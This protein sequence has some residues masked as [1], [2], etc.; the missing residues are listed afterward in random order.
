[1]IISFLLYY[2]L[3]IQ[4]LIS[5]CQSVSVAESS[6]KSVSSHSLDFSIENCANKRLPTNSTNQSDI[7]QASNHSFESSNQVD[8]SEL[9][10]QVI[11]QWIEHLE[12]FSGRSLKSFLFIVFNLSF[13]Y[14][15]PNAIWYISLNYSSSS[16]VTLLFN[17]NLLFAF[18]FSSIFLRRQFK[19]N[20]LHLVSLFL[21]LTSLVLIFVLDKHSTSSTTFGDLL[22]LSSAALYGLYQVI[23]KKLL[24]KKDIIL[25]TKE[26]L[27]FTNYVTFLI[28]IF[29]LLFQW[30]IVLFSHY[31][32]NI[33]L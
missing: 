3:T 11:L 32:S 17:T 16:K 25:S 10:P 21:A 22:A 14:S 8:Q 7:E 6:L 33:S 18:L 5:K 15:L 30:P 29:T 1:M 13:F 31:S 26:K 28:G 27:A 24:Y 2:L 20:R 4:Y 23:H 9:R 12:R 19:W